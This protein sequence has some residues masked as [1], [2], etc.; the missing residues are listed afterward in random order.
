MTRRITYFFNFGGIL[1]LVFLTGCDQASL[2]KRFTSPQDESTAKNFVDLL[3][4]QNFD[5]AENDLF[6]GLREPDTRDTMVKM[7]AMFPS[8]EPETIK[9]V[10]FNALHDANSTN[11][12]ITF[13][14]Q[15]PQQWLLATV[16]IQERDGVAS[17]AGFSVTPI[18]NSL[19]ELNRFTLAGKNSLQ[20]TV[21][22]LAVLGVLFSFYAF[23]LCIRTRIQ[24]R[25]WLWLILTL[26]GVGRFGVDWTSG[27][28]FYGYVW[29]QLPPGGAFSFPYSAWTLYFSLPLG[30]VLFLYSRKSLMASA[31]LADRAITSPNPPETAA[32]ADPA[33]AP[34]RR[35]THSA[36]ATPE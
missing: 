31:N 3:R 22:L 23:V 19:E 21:L 20:Y 17:I 28:T 25:K 30:A 33:S 8:Q 29:I 7:A 18:P 32:Q 12:S 15:F 26:L 5:E 27:Q 2:M 13:E 24:K 35:T 34:D 36:P 6:P 11:T 10:G 1:L 9:V 4:H 16:V 14:Y